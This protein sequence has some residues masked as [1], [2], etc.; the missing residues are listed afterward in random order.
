MALPKRAV[1]RDRYIINGGKI[2]INERNNNSY[3]SSF[4]NVLAVRSKVNEIRRMERA[5]EGGP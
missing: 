2:V 3:V 4:E 5:M 1:Q